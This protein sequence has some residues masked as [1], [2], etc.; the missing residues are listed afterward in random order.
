MWR[1]KRKSTLPF[2][3]RQ[4]ESTK[5]KS[6][7]INVTS[8]VAGYKV[9]LQEYIYIYVFFRSHNKQKAE[10]Q[11]FTVSSKT[12]KYLLHM[13]KDC[14]LKKKK[15]CKDQTVSLKTNLTVLSQTVYEIPQ[16]PNAYPKFLSCSGSF[17]TFFILKNKTSKSDAVDFI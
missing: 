14:I 6:L 13:Y 4:Q 11:I 8:K 3:C 7:E 2:I 17:G 15:F 10:F 12:R 16:K 9:K 5:K 1:I